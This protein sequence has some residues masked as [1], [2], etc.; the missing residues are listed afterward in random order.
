MRWKSTVGAVILAGGAA[1]AFGSLA[2]SPALFPS[3]DGPAYIGEPVAA[4]PQVEFETIRGTRESLAD[5][6]GQVVLLNIWGTWCPPCV[7]EIP[8]L[9]EV[10]E[11]IGPRGG[12][13]IGLAVES[14]SAGDIQRFWTE[15]L[16]LEPAYPLWM[17]RNRDAQR[18]FEA[19]GLPNT[20]IID[21]DGLIRARFL[22]MVTRELLLEEVE[23]YL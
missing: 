6:R 14:G 11:V 10:Q 3:G 8:H 20:L 18:H 7:R 16:E 21:R 23:P 1:L 5:Y 22:G 19:F 12:T 15:R 4:A 17:G 13:V 9:V 2:W